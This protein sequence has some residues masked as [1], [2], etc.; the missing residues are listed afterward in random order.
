MNLK[1][2]LPPDTKGQMVTCCCCGKRVPLA[3]CLADL[4]GPAFKSY[5]CS[6]CAS[7]VN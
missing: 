7:N 5:Y 3:Q 2:I 1:P 6:P 4:D